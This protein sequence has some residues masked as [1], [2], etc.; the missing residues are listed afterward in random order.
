MDN[1]TVTVALWKNEKSTPKS[2]RPFDR[3][4]RGQNWS[5][6]CGSRRAAV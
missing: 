6:A 1:V 2:R 4:E 5:W 3:S